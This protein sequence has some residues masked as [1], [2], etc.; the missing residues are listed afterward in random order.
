MVKPS[1]EIFELLAARYGLVLE[2][3]LF[4][5]DTLVNVLG[6]RAVGMRAHH[7]VSADGLRAELEALGLLTAQR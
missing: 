2:E 7:F 1:P 3:C 6:A 4:I 5:D